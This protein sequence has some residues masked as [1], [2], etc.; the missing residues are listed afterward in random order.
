[1]V[2]IPP[3]AQAYLQLGGLDPPPHAP[4][5]ADSVQTSPPPAAWERSPPALGKETVRCA[6]GAR[7]C[8]LAK[9]CIET[10]VHY[11]IT[12]RHVWEITRPATPLEAIASRGLAV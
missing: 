5:R 12:A 8:L 1:M 6:Y 11:P 10:K 9:Y 4:A 2:W 7:C 3:L